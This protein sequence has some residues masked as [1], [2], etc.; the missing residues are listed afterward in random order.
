MTMTISWSRSV[1]IAAAARGKLRRVRE[2][3]GWVTVERAPRPMKQ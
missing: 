1:A 3:D 2:S